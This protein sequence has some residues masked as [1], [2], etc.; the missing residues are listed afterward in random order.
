MRR[1]RRQ[2]H[3]DGAGARDLRV[4]AGSVCGSGL[5][6][7]VRPCA[8]PMTIA[9]TEPDKAG[10]DTRLE[11]GL[12]IRLHV[13]LGRGRVPVGVRCPFFRFCT[14]GLGPMGTWTA[15]AYLP[16][17]NGGAFARGR[18]RRAW[19]G[20]FNVVPFVEPVVET[21]APR[22]LALALR[23]AGWA[24][25]KAVACLA[26][27]CSVL[28]SAMRA[29]LLSLVL[30]G[31]ACSGAGRIEPSSCLTHQFGVGRGAPP[32]EDTLRLFG[33]NAA[34]WAIGWSP[35]RDHRLPKRGSI[36]PL[37]SIVEEGAGP[38][39]GCVVPPAVET[40]RLFWRNAAALAIG[41][42]ASGFEGSAS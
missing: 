37:P 8:S 9:S 14:R 1:S 19:W 23:T 27:W 28:A 17:A 35:S 18:G 5:N 15:P 36:S 6:R 40:T 29:V 16:M 31:T 33:R 41:W 13:S 25:A 34:T 32:L 10:D 22:E 4:R 12:S 3:A 7:P 42:P 20:Q 30:N 24:E 2:R 26:C 11:G 39:V 21:G 38:L